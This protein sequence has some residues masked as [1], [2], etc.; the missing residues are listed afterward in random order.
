MTTDR[1]P[2]AGSG[3]PSAP[4]IPQD[5]AAHPAGEAAPIAPMSDRTIAALIDIVTMSAP[6]PV[7]GMCAGL[8]WG[9][10]ARNGC[11]LSGAP[12]LFVLSVVGTIGFLY[13]WLS[14]GLFGAT[15][16]KAAMRLRVR[17]LA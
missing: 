10:V 7:V 9:G 16:G 12:A 2:A 6:V 11:V 4:T 13:L 3:E 5:A 15:L 17:D 14:E 1:I 8:K